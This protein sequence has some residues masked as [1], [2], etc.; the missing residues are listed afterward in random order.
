V[1]FRVEF[2]LEVP[3]SENFLLSDVIRLETVLLL[4]MCCFVE[5]KNEK[6]EVTFMCDGIGSNIGTEGNSRDIDC[7]LA[8]KVPFNG[9]GIGSGEAV[10]ESCS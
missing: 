3:Q 10:G 6:S 1:S 5:N 8:C 4:L 2:L 7:G 9:R